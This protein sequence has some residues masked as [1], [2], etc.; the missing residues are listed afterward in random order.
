[1]RD[2]ASRYANAHPDAGFSGDPL[3]DVWPRYYGFL[4]RPFPPAPAP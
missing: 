1:M 4:A 2:K 3:S